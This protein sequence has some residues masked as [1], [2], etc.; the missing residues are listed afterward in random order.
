MVNTKIEEFSEKK[1][2]FRSSSFCFRMASNSFSARPFT[3]IPPSSE[4]AGE[5]THPSTQAPRSP[6]EPWLEGVFVPHVYDFVSVFGPANFHGPSQIPPLY[7]EPLAVDQSVTIG[8][9]ASFTTFKRAIPAAPEMSITSSLN[10]L[11]IRA[12]RPRET[13]PQH[14]VYKIARVAFM[15]DGTPTPQTRRAMKA[16]LMELYSLRHPPLQN[17]PNI[18]K[19]LGLAWGANHFNPSHRLPVLV[20]EFADRGNLVQLQEMRDLAPAVRSRLAIDIGEGLSMLHR[21]GIIHGDVKSENILIFS[22][23]EKEYVAKLSDFGFS[24]V[25]EATNADVYVGGTRPW[26]APEAR[27]PVSRHLLQATDIY[28]YGLLLWRLA[29]DGQDPFRFWVS[30]ALQGDAYLDEL[31][32]I[33]EKDQPVQNT[34]L[35]KWFIPY[36]LA[37]GKPCRAEL[38]M[39]SLIE[40]LSKLLTVLDMAKLGSAQTGTNLS[41]AAWEA[42]MRS[43][44]LCLQAPGSSQILLG[45]FLLWAQG[46]VFYGR[47]PFTLNNCLSIDP[48]KRDLHEALNTLTGHSR[49]QL[50][51]VYLF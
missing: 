46:D 33:K 44:E 35:E 15:E 51:Y 16:A 25:R 34:S 32:Q 17:H 40:A 2:K 27:S 1:K 19:F 23:S 7:L 42:I 30:S 29:T 3:S 39:D 48:T 41:T 8:H 21:C 14:V 11:S 4:A 24:M 37:K 22:H 31:E 47:I 49:P 6:A 9:G 13:R 45:R 36:I 28:S 43:L 50:G 26:K 10:G 20:V 5:S 12:S 38:A 18:V